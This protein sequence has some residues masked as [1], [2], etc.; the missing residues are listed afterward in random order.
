MRDHADIPIMKEGIDTIF[1]NQAILSKDLEWSGTVVRATNH[2]ALFALYMAIQSQPGKETLRLE[3]DK[4]QNTVSDGDYPH[5]L[6][7]YPKVSLA[8]DSSHIRALEISSQLVS[9]NNI[10]AL[11]LWQIMHPDPLSHKN[12]SLAIPAEIKANCSLVT[13]QKLAALKAPEIER[14][15]TKLTDIVDGSQTLLT[16]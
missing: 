6:N 15:A 8:A 4:E 10:R 16:A 9:K 1:S 11:S 13:Q 5:R 2:R 12:D 3:P 7:H 14:D